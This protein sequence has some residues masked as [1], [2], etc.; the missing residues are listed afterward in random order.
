[1]IQR[2]T[3]ILLEKKLRKDKDLNLLLIIPTLRRV[4][5]K[6]LFLTSPAGI[7][8]LMLFTAII[9]LWISW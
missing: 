1:M 2:L 8:M 4:R 3:Y 9:F 7:P 5:N 6:I